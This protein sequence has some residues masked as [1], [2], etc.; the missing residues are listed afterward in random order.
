MRGRDADDIEKLVRM[1]HAHGIDHIFIT[2]DNFA[3]HPDWESIADRLIQLKEKEGLEIY[4]MI[5]V[6][7]LAHRI[8]RFIEKMARAGCRRVFIGIE[9]VNPD[10][11]LAT[12]KRQNR[13]SEYRR[14][15][16]A[17]R[18]HGVVTYAGYIIG[19]PG[20]TYESIMRDVEYLKRELPLDFAEFFIMTPLP[21]SKDHQKY[22]LNHIPMDHDMNRYETNHVVM[23][24]PKMNR[25]E[26]ERAYQDA[27]RSFYSKEHMFTLLKRRRKIGGGHRV[28]FS[29]IWFRSCIFAEGV[30]PLLGGI[31]RF[32]GRKNRRLSFPRESFLPYY[33]RRAVEIVSNLCKLGAIALEVHLLRMKSKHSEYADYL[34]DAI[35]PEPKEEKEQNV[36]GPLKTELVHIAR[37]S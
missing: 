37:V 36:P 20:D 28:A 9:S 32:K 18:N 11:L 7:T 31:I 26:L 5:Q 14:M 23:D 34:D 3:R 25:G 21:G 12:D 16:Q 22:Y 10:N 4:L 15:L 24:H 2:D 27:W 8:P 30:H 29:L 19:F 6:D 1:N 33:I 13:I 17:W 35:T